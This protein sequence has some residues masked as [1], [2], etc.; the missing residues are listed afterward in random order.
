MQENSHDHLTKQ[1]ETVLRNRTE[2]VITAISFTLLEE[3][4]CDTIF[5]KKK[6][7]KRICISQLAKKSYQEQSLR[8]FIHLLAEFESHNHYRDKT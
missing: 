3:K 7:K 1:G 4:Q 5:Y 6:R 2:V 8:P